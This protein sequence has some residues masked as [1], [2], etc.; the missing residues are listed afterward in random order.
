VADGWR[1]TKVRDTDHQ[2]VPAQTARLSKDGLDGPD[3][4]LRV[5]TGANVRHNPAIL[6]RRSEALFVGVVLGGTIFVGAGLNTRRLDS[7]IERL[8]A[9]CQDEDEKN[10]QKPELSIDFQLICDPAE[11]A[12]GKGDF[13]GVEGAIAKAQQRRNRWEEWCEWLSST[14][15]LIIAIGILPSAW[16][17]L[18]ARIR[19][20]S[21]ASTGK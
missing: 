7:Q 2:P 1:R 13:H 20:L 8:R 18:R 16:H 11:L 10:H 5:Q 15:L 6:N 9:D 14:G 3:K 4:T 17:F 12:S 21:A 19:E